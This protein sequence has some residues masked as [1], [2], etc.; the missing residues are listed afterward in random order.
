MEELA[1]A[2]L[3]LAEPAAVVIADQVF[4]SIYLH[5]VDICYETVIDVSQIRNH[6][7]LHAQ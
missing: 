6:A 3:H 4:D 5:L 7:L 1:A 2:V